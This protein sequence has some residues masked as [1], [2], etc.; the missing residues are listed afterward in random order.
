V[1]GAPSVFVPLKRSAA[2]SVFVRTNGAEAASCPDASIGV[3]PARRPETNGFSFRLRP[4]QANYLALSGRIF[5]M[6][7]RRQ[8]PEDDLGRLACSQISPLG[9]AT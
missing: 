3:G 5:V 9:A 8:D 2:S 1:L 6:A 7:T 4:A